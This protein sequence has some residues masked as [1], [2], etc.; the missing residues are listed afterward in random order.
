MEKIAQYTLDDDP[1]P[2]TVSLCTAES[3]GDVAH[4]IKPSNTHFVLFLALDATAIGHE[5]ILSA[6]I[7]LLARGM[8]YICVWGPDCERVHD[9]FDEADIERNPQ[10]TE[11][12]V[13][14]S[15]WHS[16]NSLEEAIEFFLY[17]AR[18]TSD[19]RNTC[20]DWVAAVIGNSGW[21]LQVRASLSQAGG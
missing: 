18:P 10:L 12:N 3:L 16:K 14:M 21:E 19:Y 5:V 9:I 1:S 8:V 13:V 17:C 20:S 2:K 4:L 15:T 6:A 7:E 11:A